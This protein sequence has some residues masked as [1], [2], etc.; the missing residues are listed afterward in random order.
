MTQAVSRLPH[1]AEAR[2]LARVSL[3]GICDGPSGTG[4]GFSPSYSVSPV[5]IIPSSY[6]HII[7][8]SVQ[9]HNL[10]PSNGHGQVLL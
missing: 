8:A 9:R 3:C 2:V 7:W 1:T 5:N 6:S 10:N 4:T